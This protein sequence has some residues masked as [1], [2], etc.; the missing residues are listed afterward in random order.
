VADEITA[1][2]RLIQARHVLVA[3]D[4]CYSG[5][6][7][8]GLGV[9]PARPSEREQFLQRMAAGRSRTLMASGGDAPVADGG[10]GHSVFAAALLR[11]LREMGGPRFTAFELFT[12]YV[13]APV[14]ARTERTPVYKPLPDSGHESGDFVFTRVKPAPAPGSCDDPEAKAKLYE[15]FLDDFEGSPERQKVAYGAG[16][17]YVARYENCPKESDK[18]VVGYVRKWLAKY[19]AAVRE[20]RRWQSRRP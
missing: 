3:S 17:E 15:T 11:G 2:I 16:K 4:S 14:A 20:W 18:N 1:G 7:A 12:A 9:T 10:G 19:E 6:L 5:A 8:G 13:V